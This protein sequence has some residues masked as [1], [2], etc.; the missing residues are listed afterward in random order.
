MK[1]LLRIPTHLEC[2]IYPTV[3]V[4]G[5]LLFVEVLGAQVLSE[6]L[7]LTLLPVN[8]CLQRDNL[9]DTHPVHACAVHAHAVIG[10]YPLVTEVDRRGGPVCIIVVYRN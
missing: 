3:K 10:L 1:V 9:Q 8:T 5:F 4:K 6:K 2:V 7:E